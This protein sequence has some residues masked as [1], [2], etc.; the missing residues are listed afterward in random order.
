MVNG[1]GW[2]QDKTA[3]DLN[4]SQQAVST[5]IQIAKAVEDYPELAKQRKGSVIL[6][7]FKKEE[8]IIKLY[9][10]AWNTQEDIAREINCDQ[11]TVFN[12]LGNFRKKGKFPE[13]PM[14]QENGRLKPPFRT[15]FYATSEQ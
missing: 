14:L 11:K 2:T 3:K 1:E 6:R 4:I 13:I 15:S 5:V 9:L 8:K 10:Q 12:V 7:E